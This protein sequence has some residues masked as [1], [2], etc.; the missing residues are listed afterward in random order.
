M[1]LFQ[2]QQQLTEH[3]KELRL[4]HERELAQLHQHFDPLIAAAS[5]LASRHEQQSGSKPPASSGSD[6]LNCKLPGRVQESHDERELGRPQPSKASAFSPGFKL[7]SPSSASSSPVPTTLASPNPSPTSSIPLP[8][9]PP[10]STNAVNRA[11]SSSTEPNFSASLSPFGAGVSSS[12][13]RSIVVRQM[14]GKL[15]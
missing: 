7:I 2:L 14:H 15:L 4:R 13:R 11:G 8:S 10:S 3:L 9:L 12:Y 5:D 6:D 1:H